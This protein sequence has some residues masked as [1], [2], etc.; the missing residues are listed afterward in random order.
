MRGLRA[1]LGMAFG[2]AFG[3]I[4][5]LLVFDSWWAP[6][7]GASLGLLIGAVIDLQTPRDGP[8]E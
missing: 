5:G 4:F 8:S 1:G 3:L 2:A 7:A 6:V